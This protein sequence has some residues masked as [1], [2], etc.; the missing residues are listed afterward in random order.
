MISDLVINKIIFCV[1]LVF[2]NLNFLAIL[3]L[4]TFKEQNC[5]YL[6]ILI[7]SKNYILILYAFFRS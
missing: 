1:L 7:P 5:E 4:Q 2:N 6:N 3:N